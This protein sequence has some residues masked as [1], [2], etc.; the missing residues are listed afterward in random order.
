VDRW[1]DPAFAREEGTMLDKE[2]KAGRDDIIFNIIPVF[3]GTGI[4]YMLRAS[5]A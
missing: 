5:Q 3:F 2:E 4:Y 1:H